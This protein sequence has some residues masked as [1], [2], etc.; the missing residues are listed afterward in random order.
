MPKHREHELFKLADLVFTGGQTLYEAKRDQH[1]AV[2]AFPSSI[3][4]D[5]FMQARKGIENRKIKSTFRI[6]VS[7]FSA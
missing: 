3:D 5:H 7:A 4:R 2:Y 6:R 1:H